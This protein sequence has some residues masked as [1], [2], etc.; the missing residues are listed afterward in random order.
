MSDVLEKVYTNKELRKTVVPLFIGNPGLGKTKIIEQFAKN[1]EVQLLEFITSQMSPFEISGIAIPDKDVK[2]MVYYNFDKLDSLKDGDILFFDEL[3]NG[4]P[5]VLNACLTVLEQ[6]KMISGKPLPDVMIIAAANPQGAVPLTPQIKER[7]VWYDVKFNKSMWI[8]YMI[9][10]YNITTDIGNKL[11]NLI[12]TEDFTGT[13]Y[14]TPRSLDKAVNMIIND[15]CTPY[16]KSVLPILEELVINTSKNNIKLTDE[17]DFLPGEALKWIDLI[18]FNQFIS[19][20]PKRKYTRKLKV[21]KITIEKAAE[22][23]AKIVEDHYEEVIPAPVE[24]RSTTEL[25]TSF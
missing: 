6:R 10:K 3:L 11:S 23:A 5:T 8:N 13:N 17:R 20:K 19:I 16:S 15:V 21:E 25:E 18:R 12:T 14:C 9:D 7:F 22:I 1:K 24:T 4:N 2:K